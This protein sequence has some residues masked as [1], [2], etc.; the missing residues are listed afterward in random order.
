M[1]FGARGLVGAT[2]LLD[3][4]RLDQAVVGAF[5][6]RVALGI[7][8]SAVAFTNLPRLVAEETAKIGRPVPVY[9]VHLKPAMREKLLMG[10]TR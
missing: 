8:V 2:S 5:L 1:G 4:Y 6:S 3:T 9:C 10:L 7:Y